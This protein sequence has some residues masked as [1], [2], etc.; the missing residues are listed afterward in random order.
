MNNHKTINYNMKNVAKG[1]LISSLMILMSISFTKVQA[2]DNQKVDKAMAEFCNSVNIF[3]ESLIILDEANGSGSVDAFNIAYNKA[4]KDWDKLQKAAEK[5][6]KVE[7]TQSVKAYNKLVDSV[8][9]MSKDG[10]TDEE[11]DELNDYI[12]DTADEINAILSASCQ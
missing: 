2:Q 3:V 8:N 12:D 5:V 7:I 4:V 1:I 11:S 6:E 10:F 9:K